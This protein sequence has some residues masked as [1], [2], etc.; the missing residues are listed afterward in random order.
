MTEQCA[1]IWTLSKMHPA[2]MV[3]ERAAPSLYTGPRLNSLLALRSLNRMALSCTENRAAITDEDTKT[4]NWWLPITHLLITVDFPC[5]APTFTCVYLSVA[6]VKWQDREN[7]LTHRSKFLRAILESKKKQSAQNKT[8]E[9][10]TKRTWLILI[11]PNSC[12]D[13]QLCACTL[14]TLRSHRLWRL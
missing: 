9:C 4:F 7:E 13:S 8:K 14:C 3:K 2:W 10:L 12:N 5:H 1:V 11:V 6:S